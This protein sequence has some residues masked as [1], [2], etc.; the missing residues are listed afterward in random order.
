[1]NDVDFVLVRR[2]VRAYAPPGVFAVYHGLGL[3]KIRKYPPAEYLDERLRGN[4]DREESDAYN[5]GRLRYF[6]DRLLAGEELDPIIVDN[7][8]GFGCIYPEPIVI[9][10][11]HRLWSY[12]IARRQRIPVA[13]SGRVDVLDYLTGKRAR[14]PG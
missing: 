8:C 10:G 3:R 6:V 13:Y 9:D 4:S 5:F 1:M 2:L 11:H 7:R 14:M 12:L